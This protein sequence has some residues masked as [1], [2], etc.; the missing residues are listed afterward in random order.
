[1]EYRCETTS[2]EGMIQLL[3][4]NYLPHGY[5]FYVTGRVPD[6]KDPRSVDTKLIG[7]YGIARSRAARSRQKQLGY[8]NMHYLRHGR[9]FILLA[10]HGKHHF[11]EDEA[12]CIRDARRTPIKFAGYAVSYRRGGRVIAGAVDAKWHS[13]VEIDREWYKVLQAWFMDTAIRRS[14]EKVANDFYR[15]PFEPYA[16]VRR[17]LLRLLQC[18]NTARKQAGQPV[19]PYEVLPLRRRVV[20]PFEA[21]QGQVAAVDVGGILSERRSAVGPK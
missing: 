15:V 17:Q 11:F 2:V 8:A 12:D 6:D 21:K 5:W 9:C 14:V 7:K 4:C 20:R 1:M 13:H 18:V 16:P 3:A 19:L 10:T